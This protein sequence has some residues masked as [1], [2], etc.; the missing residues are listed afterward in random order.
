MSKSGQRIRTIAKKELIEFARDWRTILAILV[1]PLLLF[2]VLFILFP[3]L[4]ESEAEERELMELSIE[5]QTNLDSSEFEI[6]FE[7]SK[8]NV[9]YSSLQ[10]ENLSFISEGETDALR[11]LNTDAILKLEKTNST[12]TY[13]LFYLST[14]EQSLES[15]SRILLILEEWEQVEVE[16]RIQGAG[17]DIEETLDP[18]RYD[19]QFLANDVATKGEQSGMILSLFIP[20][21]LSVWTFTSAIQ[22]SIDMTVAEKERGTLEALLGLPCSRRELLLGKWL[23]VGTI[24]AIGVA[25]Q[26]AGLL[27]AITYLASTNLFSLPS[28]S[29]LSLTLLFIAVLLFAIM[30]VAIELAIAI[31]SHS[32]KEAGSILGPAVLFILFPALFSQVINL[33]NIESF[34]FAI[35]VVNVLLALRELLMDRVVFDHI[36]IWISTSLLYAATAAMYAS[37]QFKREDLVTSIS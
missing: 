31:R 7:N 11:S 18:I 16:T 35:P 22:P 33:D 20:L 15:R 24:T 23:A 8:L 13:S 2:P 14:S 1:I 4:L 29:A 30:V 34:W 27:F 5:I 12:Y 26:I 36:L 17:L 19:G 37:K 3:V 28:L 25:L 9:M 6:Y 21:V 10:D 32:V